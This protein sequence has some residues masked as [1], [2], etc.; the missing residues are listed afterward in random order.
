MSALW[1]ILKF[2]LSR[3]QKNKPKYSKLKKNKIIYQKCKTKMKE[4]HNIQ[5][6]ALKP[7]QHTRDP[8]SKA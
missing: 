1:D 6:I 3:S 7:Y 2:Y 8:D 4:V 5:K